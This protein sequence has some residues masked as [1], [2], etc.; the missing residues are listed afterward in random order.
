MLELHWL[1]APTSVRLFLVYLGLSVTLVI[2]RAVRLTLRFFT[3]R[4]GPVSVE[5]LRD[6]SVSP[7]SF[8]EYA[9]ANRVRYEPTPGGSAR[10]PSGDSSQLDKSRNTPDD[11]GV[12]R[13]L[14]IANSKFGYTSGLSEIEIGSIRRLFWLTALLSMLVL[15]SDAF[16]TWRGI[17]ENGTITGF[18]AIRE[19]IRRLFDWLSFALEACAL[20][21]VILSFLEGTLQRRQVSWQYFCLRTSNELSAGSTQNADGV[22]HPL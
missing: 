3:V 21:Y 2:I 11:R 16:A 18:E 14:R 5:A 8:A 13:A 22:P 6:E 19:T 15:A 12:L 10:G 4:V 7:D 17:F 20:I 9:L 1:A